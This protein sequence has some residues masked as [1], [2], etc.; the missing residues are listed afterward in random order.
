[1]LKLFANL[2]KRNDRPTI[3]NIHPAVNRGITQT[4]NTLNGG[5]LQCHYRSYKETVSLKGQTAHNH[6]CGCSK[7]WKPKDALLSQ[8][9]VIP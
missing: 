5:K 1:M 6:I 2:F 3:I 8:V 4:N 7:Y 9:A